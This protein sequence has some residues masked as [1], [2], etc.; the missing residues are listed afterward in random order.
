MIIYTISVDTSTHFHFYIQSSASH[1]WYNCVQGHFSFI[2]SVGWDEHVKIISA[3]KPGRE[4]CLQAVY[5][6]GSAM[7]V[8]FALL[9]VAAVESKP[10]PQRCFSQSKVPFKKKSLC[11]LGQGILL[12]WKNWIFGII[13]CIFQYQDF[14][15]WICTT[16][17]Y[18]LIASLFHKTSYR[19]SFTLWNCVQ[20]TALY[21]LMKTGFFFR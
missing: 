16:S 6:A 2:F 1:H 12:Q 18:S 11:E 9:V 8:L 14:C 5:W 13:P 21:Y 4:L 7:K 20:N 15:V 19:Y 17:K 3:Y 10:I